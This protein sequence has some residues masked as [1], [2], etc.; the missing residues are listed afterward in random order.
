VPDDAVDAV[1]PDAP[2]L[3]RCVD[4]LV[5]DG[6]VAREPGAGPDDPVTYRLPA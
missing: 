6:L 2:Q 3:A 5:A 1:W 4:G